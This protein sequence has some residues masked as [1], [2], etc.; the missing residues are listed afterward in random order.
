MSVKAVHILKI[1]ELVCVGV[2]VSGKFLYLCHLNDKYF[3][4]EDIPA[5]Q[6]GHV[7]KMLEL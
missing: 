7:E 2:N 1:N 4:F 5:H 3:F 6:S